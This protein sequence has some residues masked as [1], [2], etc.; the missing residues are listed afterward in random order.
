MIDGQTG[1]T[2]VVLTRDEERNL[3]ALLS[4]VEALARE[5]YVVDSGSRDSTIAIAEHFGAVVVNHSFESHSKQWQWALANLPIKTDWV[6][7]LDA[8]QR[9]T[10]ELRKRIQELVAKSDGADS[11]LEGC[12]VRRRQ[13]FRGKWI[14]H[15]GYYPKYLLKLFRLNSVSID[16][17]DL[18]D[19]HFR[20]RGRTI[21]LEDDIIEDNQNEADISVW[22][23]KHNRYAMRQA[24]EE[25]NRRYTNSHVA[26]VRAVL[27]G[28]P[29]ERTE[30]LKRLWCRLPLYI[31]PALY[32]AYRYFLRLG[33]LDGK[34]GFIFHFLQGFWYRLLVDV[35]LD[36]MPRDTNKRKVNDPTNEAVTSLRG[37]S[38]PDLRP[39]V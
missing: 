3:G 14:R 32:F 17:S 28:S 9:L 39:R 7:A 15:G 1:V 8:D 35:N 10:P 22:I 36:Q 38:P 33:F 4:S 27:W 6:L 5:V 13:V 16:E 2:L 19:H 11:D 29:D 23:D 31:R 30:W 12:Y 20:V 21:R 25:F 26:N 37:V 34:Q 18:V 24:T